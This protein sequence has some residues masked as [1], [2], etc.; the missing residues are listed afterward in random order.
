MN[1]V[2][3]ALSLGAIVSAFAFATTAQASCRENH[4]QGALGQIYPSDSKEK[5][6]NIVMADGHKGLN[7]ANQDYLVLKGSH[8]NFKETY[9]LLLAAQFAKHPVKVRIQEGS[10]TCEILYVT[11][12]AD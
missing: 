7:C 3:I 4:C 10:S 12:I 1:S 2:K 8:V 9:A 5:L 6:I 11:T